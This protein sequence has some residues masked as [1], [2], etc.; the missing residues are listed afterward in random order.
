MASTVLP[1][2]PTEY[3]TQLDADLL[4]GL[5]VDAK[6]NIL[7]ILEI[8]SDQDVDHIAGAPVG[9]LVGN[10]FKKASTNFSQSADT[11]GAGALLASIDGGL[12]L[13][14]ATSFFAFVLVH[15]R[16]GDYVSGNVVSDG[17]VAAGSKLRFA[18][19]GAWGIYDGGADDKIIGVSDAADSSTDLSAADVFINAL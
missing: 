15:G 3:V 14:A 6:G 18:A 8:V 7:R 4:G 17:N 16:L 9:F 19:D 12:L 2:S 10:V 1:F 13:A 11:L 5:Y